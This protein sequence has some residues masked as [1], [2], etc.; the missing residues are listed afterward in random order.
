VLGRSDLD[1]QYFQRFMFIST[2]NLAVILI[3]L[4][5]GA[6]IFSR[7]LRSSI[8]ANAEL[9][10]RVVERTSELQEAKDAAEEAN[11]YKSHFLANMSHELRTPLNAVLGYAQILRYDRTLDERQVAG[12]TTIQQSGEHL[13]AL[14]NDILD[15]AKIEVGKL[16]LVPATVDL[17][18]FLRVI[19]DIIRIKAEQKKLIFRYEV[20]PDLPDTIWADPQRLREILLNLLDN[21]VKFTDQGTVTLRVEVI[22]S[23]SAIEPGPT[24]NLR[25]AIEDTGIGI[26]A[27]Q[28]ERIFRPFEQVGE[29]QR[30][31]EGTGLGLA[32]SRQLVRLMGGEL[33]VESDVGQGS[34]FWFELALPVV[35]AIGANQPVSPPITGYTGPQYRLLIVD[36]I[37]ANR[38]MLVQLLASLGFDI[39]EATNGQEALALAQARPPDLVVLDMRMPLMDGLEVARRLRQI[40]GLHEMPIIA[41]SASASKADQ[42]KSLEVGADAF[43][44][45]PIQLDVLL[46]E[47]GRLLQLTWL[48]ERELGGL[49]L[50]GSIEA[51]SLEAPPSEE[52][53]LLYEL[54]LLGK[55]R[56]IRERAASLEQ[57]NPKYRPFAAQLQR[58]AWKFDIKQV[59][60]LLKRYMEVDL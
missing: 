16:D 26:P 49:V 52:L 2:T 57:L 48:Y 56:Q 35:D 9:E 25:F 37:G 54:A 51:P 42:T 14:I 40:P 12:L 10:Q 4:M 28:I 29:A 7:A 38:T 53:E 55:M 24:C 44:P 19:A 41:V 23:G 31:V 47:I 11:R 17:A 36:D 43:V 30:R 8:A 21:A 33:L 50:P 6:T 58:L 27:D 60:A 34:R 20:S 46:S 13:L 5:V 18:P 3:L 59:Q 15:L 39:V 1:P 22:D 32:I 45:K